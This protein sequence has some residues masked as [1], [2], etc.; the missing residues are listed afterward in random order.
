MNRNQDMEREEF[1][2]LSVEDKLD[3]FANAVYSTIITL[4]D[5]VAAQEENIK[6]LTV[7][8]L[9]HEQSMEAIRAER[10]NRN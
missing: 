7:M 6:L 10:G 4:E 2:N 3:R 8:V 5:T 9:N 1:N